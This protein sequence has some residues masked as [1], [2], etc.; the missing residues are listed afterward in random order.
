MDNVTVQKSLGD[1]M[2]AKREGLGL[3]QE[4][5][6]DHLGMHRAYYSALERGEKNLT[7]QTLARVAQGL[8]TTV[9]ALAKDAAI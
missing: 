4:R 1:A 7:I 6:A 8:K 2:R 5:F 3:S 9:A